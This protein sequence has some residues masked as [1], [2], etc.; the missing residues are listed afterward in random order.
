ME[1]KIDLLVAVIAENIELGI[2]VTPLITLI[3][4]LTI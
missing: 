3:C 4:W 1:K 2:F